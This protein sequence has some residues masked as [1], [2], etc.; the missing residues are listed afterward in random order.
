MLNGDY[1]RYLLSDA[2]SVKQWN[3]KKALKAEGTAK[4]YLVYLNNY[5]T[6]VLSSSFKT[7]D[8][9]TAQVQQEQ[10]S[11]DINIRRK[12]ATDLEAFINSYVS[13]MTKRPLSASGKN[14][15]IASVTSYLHHCLGDK[16]ESYDFELGTKAERMAELRRKEDVAPVEIHEVKRLYNEAQSHRDKAIVSMIL[17][18]GCGVAEVMQFADE[19]YKYVSD[20]RETKVPVR[21]NV[22]RPKTMQSYTHFLWD[23]CVDD[24]KELL[25]ERERDLGRPITSSDSLFVTQTGKPIDT[26]EIQ[27]VFRRLADRSG[28]EPKD[29]NKVSYRIRPHEV[30]KDLYRTQL[31]LARVPK[32][33]AEYLT[34]HVV[35]GNAY[36]KYHKLPEGQALI[37]KEAA[38]LRPLLN[39]RTGRG[40]ADTDKDTR[41]IAAEELLKSVFPDLWEKYEIKV[42]T[43]TV[44]EA[45]RWIRESIKER[46]T[47]RAPIETEYQYERIPED[48]ADNHLNHGW[49]FVQVLPSGLLLIRKKKD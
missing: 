7:I 1:P 32:D 2:D 43:L 44:D 40:R 31:A 21:I 13:P 36:N 39:L 22:T 16:L 47:E 33:I 45:L 17:S 23:D 46:T 48:K 30:G 20:I 14:Q 42:R 41:L 49:Q 38:K 3:A 11:K 25:L 12:W 10:D 35:D 4:G 5:W 26:K 19:W 34:G 29:K 37:A 9:W 18:G 15:V 24:L 6:R 8:E 28:L 27:R